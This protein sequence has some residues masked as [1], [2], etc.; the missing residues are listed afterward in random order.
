MYRALL[1]PFAATATICVTVA[2]PLSAASPEDRAPMGRKVMCS[3]DIG[4][5]LRFPYNWFP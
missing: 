3:R 4:F 1:L 2:A 5:T